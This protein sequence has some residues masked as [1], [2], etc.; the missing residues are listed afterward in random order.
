LF[1][2]LQNSE[3]GGDSDSDD[4][5]A[6]PAN[7]YHFQRRKFNFSLLSFTFETFGKKLAETK[8]VAKVNVKKIKAK[9]IDKR[10][11]NHLRC[12]GNN[13]LPKFVNNGESW[14]FFGRC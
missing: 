4:S 5:S 10:L 7:F 2:S 3:G 12:S 11:L 13:F 8:I 14:R 1:S 6:D 9:K